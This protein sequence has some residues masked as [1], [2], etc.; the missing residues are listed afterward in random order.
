[1]TR[2]EAMRAFDWFRELPVGVAVHGVF[3]K[4]HAVPNAA[5]DASWQVTVSP[6]DHDDFHELLDH[7]EAA[8]YRIG[9]RGFQDGFYVLTAEEHQRRRVVG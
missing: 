5:D 7:A 8:G 4:E 1:M 9:P 2:G 6:R 3:I